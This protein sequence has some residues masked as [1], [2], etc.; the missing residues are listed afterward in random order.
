MIWRLGVT[1]KR[2][3]VAIRNR[4]VDI[5]SY[6]VVAVV[7][8]ELL[9]PLGVRLFN[10][11]FTLRLPQRG[12]APSASKRAP[13]CT[14]LRPRRGALLSRAGRNVILAFFR[15]C[16]KNARVRADLSAGPCFWGRG[17]S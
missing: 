16:L 14:M 17:L 7:A 8:F 3:A 1:N 10:A 4:W 11:A 9:L 5:L 15:Q 2:I 12:F 6:A 13:A